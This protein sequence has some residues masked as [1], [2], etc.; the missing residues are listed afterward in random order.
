MVTDAPGSVRVGPADD[1]AS[2]LGPL[3]DKAAVARV[4][5]LVKEAADYA[6]VLVRGGVP[7]APEL[8]DGA[9]YRPSLIE[10]D[11]VDVPVVQEEVFGPV[12]TFEV[13][14]KRYGTTR[15]R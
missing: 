6:K 4:D 2:Q 14:V 7:D 1:P 3:I 5:R 11:D 10:T 12:Q 9:F 15:P 8:R 13:F